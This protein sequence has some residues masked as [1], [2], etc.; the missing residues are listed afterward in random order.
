[1]AK[2]TLHTHHQV[3]TASSVL[4]AQ[5]DVVNMGS[6]RSLLDRGLIGLC[7][8]QKWGVTL[9]IPVHLGALLLLSPWKP[10]LRCHLHV[11]CH[12]FR[13]KHKHLHVPVKREGKVETGGAFANGSEVCR[14]KSVDNHGLALP[15]PSSSFNC[16]VSFSSTFL[17]FVCTYTTQN[18]I[19]ANVHKEYVGNVFVRIYLDL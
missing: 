6:S 7:L 5:D 13:W 8:E 4:I 11:V 12:G 1:M 16:V 3:A 19:I 17:L 18:S 15:S 9:C 2:D 14:L 10:L